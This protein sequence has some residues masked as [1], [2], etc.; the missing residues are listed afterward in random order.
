MMSERCNPPRADVPPLSVIA[1]KLQHMQ[2][3]NRRDAASGS[4]PFVAIARY[5]GLHRDTVYAA[6]SGEAIGPMVQM[7]LSRFLRR[8]ELGEL[9]AER[10]KG[11]WEVVVVENPKLPLMLRVD[12]GLGGSGPKLMGRTPQ[13][14]P[15]MPSFSKLFSDGQSD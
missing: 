3:L 14:S 10:V 7:L 4:F 13:P 1:Q 9:R 6:A 11:Q 12:F 15:I 2:R 8:I 5:L